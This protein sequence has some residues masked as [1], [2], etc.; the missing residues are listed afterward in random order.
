MTTPEAS[1]S[2]APTI[3]A[4]R[5]AAIVLTAFTVRQPFLTLNEITAV[6]ATSKATAH[7]YTKALREAGL[8][9]YDEQTSL[10]SLGRQ[11]LRL[12]SSA[13]A[14]LPLIALSRS[15]LEDLAQRVRQTA[16]LS[17]WDG[18]GPTVISSVDGGD[19]VVSVSI[20]PG[21]R[22][23]PTFSA[24]G[25]VFC[26]FL[27]K[28]QVP[29][30]GDFLARTPGLAEELREIKDLGV[31]VSTSEVTGVHSIAAPVLVGDEAAASVAVVGAATA[32]PRGRQD[33]TVRVLIETAHA[34][35]RELSAL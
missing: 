31:C 1:G 26:S 9:V 25:R 10:Y 28:D 6:L 14:G 2:T 22:L 11:V 19:H 17:I 21:A 24:Q 27:P 34:M 20:R 29:R 12:G 30:L 3:Q 4:V 13:R 33:V 16:V 18:E 32:I 5:R 15:Y 23:D 7:R 8:L 35:S